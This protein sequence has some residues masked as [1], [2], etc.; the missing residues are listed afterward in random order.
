[1][2]KRVSLLA[3]SCVFS[4]SLEGPW[5]QTVEEIM[6]A[7]MRGFMH[8]HARVIEGTKTDIVLR[9]CDGVSSVEGELLC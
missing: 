6:H 1:M 7:V 8:H 5:R 3:A 4:S 2:H 9:F